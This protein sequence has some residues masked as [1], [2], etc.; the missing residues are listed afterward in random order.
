MQAIVEVDKQ[1]RG[2]KD[3]ITDFHMASNRERPIRFYG[4]AFFVSANLNWNSRI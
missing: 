4:R 1:Q 2:L 3:I